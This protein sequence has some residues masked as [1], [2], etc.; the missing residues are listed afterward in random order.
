M[1]AKLAWKVTRKRKVEAESDEVFLEASG[2]LEENVSKGKK[3][4]ERL[5]CVKMG[6]SSNKEREEKENSEMSEMNG[7]QKGSGNE[8]K[9]RDEW[10]Y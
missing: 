10:K 6:K 2:G 7:N 4:E 1:R 8:E 3:E 5:K 9:K